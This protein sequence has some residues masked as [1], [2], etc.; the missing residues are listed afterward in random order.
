LTWLRERDQACHVPGPTP[1]PST[2][3]P[4]PPPESPP[5]PAGFEQVL[6]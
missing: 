6:P 1:A 5:R 4:L 2:T 3:V